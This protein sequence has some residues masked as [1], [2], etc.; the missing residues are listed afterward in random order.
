M[1]SQNSPSDAWAVHDYD[2]DRVFRGDL[3]CFAANH[4]IP[5]LPDGLRVLLL[6]R[7]L[8]RREGLTETTFE[9]SGGVGDCQH[10]VP[11][12]LLSR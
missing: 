3:A 11:A 1:E 4:N 9:S 7:G 2:A 12:F 8:C 6:C 10:A 5:T